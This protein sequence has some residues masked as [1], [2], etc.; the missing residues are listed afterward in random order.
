MVKQSGYGRKNKEVLKGRTL[1]RTSCG[2]RYKQQ[3][4]KKMLEERAS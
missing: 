3:E 1:R 4:L 2:R